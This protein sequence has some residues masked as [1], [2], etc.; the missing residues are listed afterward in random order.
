MDIH[1]KQK[2]I[3]ILSL[4]FSI[5]ADRASDCLGQ[6]EQIRAHLC[7]R[8]G[9]S[10]IP[11][12]GEV[13]LRLYPFDF[14]NASIEPRGTGLLSYIQNK[15]LLAIHM[16]TLTRQILQRTDVPGEKE[17]RHIYA[18][19]AAPNTVVWARGRQVVVFPRVLLLYPKFANIA[20]RSGDFVG[21][22]S[23]GNPPNPDY[24]RNDP[25]Y[26]HLRDDVG[27]AQKSPNSRSEPR[28]VVYSNLLRGS[29]EATQSVEASGI[30]DVAE[31]F[32]P[33]ESEKRTKQFVLVVHVVRRQ[34]NGLEY[35]LLYPDKNVGVLST[36]GAIFR[37]LYFEEVDEDDWSEPWEKQFESQDFKL[38]DGDKVETMPADLLVFP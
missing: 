5:F 25:I 26:T 10:S 12:N 4:L 2:F 21:T 9:H 31:L 35:L 15:D 27:Y 22:V 7:K 33:T 1:L 29:A 20:I 17:L 34:L 3:L 11:A 30:K 37:S 28:T 36:S 38:I 32:V 16:E 18:R 13:V 14:E 8:F 6:A 23:L 24:K 19:E